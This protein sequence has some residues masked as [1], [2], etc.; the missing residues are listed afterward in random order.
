MRG[1]TRSDAVPRLGAMSQPNVPRR[2]DGRLSAR[3]VVLVGALFGLFAMHGLGDHGAS[4]HEMHASA[5]APAI[6]DA[7][8]AHGEH[9]SHADARDQSSAAD[10]AAAPDSPSP[11]MWMAGL[12]LAV[13]VGAL[14]GF[15][16]ARPQRVVVFTWSNALAFVPARHSGRRDRD[17]PCLLK[18]S[19]LRT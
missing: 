18:L 8:P 11:G 19:V 16:L 2:M 10:P 3:L 9:S 12:C 7:D 1:P 6:V 15:L 4:P 5:M 17:P 13:L 14:I